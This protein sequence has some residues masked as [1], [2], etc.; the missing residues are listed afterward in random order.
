MISANSGIIEA[1]DRLAGSQPNRPKQG[2]DRLN[3][4][5]RRARLC[6]LLLIMASASLASAIGD[7]L[8]PGG[9]LQL[10]G[11]PISTFGMSLITQIAAVLV[12]LAL[13]AA[14]CRTSLR[15]AERQGWILAAIAGIAVSLVIAWL[16]TIAGPGCSIGWLIAPVY[17]LWAWGSAASGL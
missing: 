12:A 6:P 4:T 9:W 13:A 7:L 10:V 16:G 8:I 3:Q 1:Y 5:G 15:A 11:L 14:L 2:A 17:L